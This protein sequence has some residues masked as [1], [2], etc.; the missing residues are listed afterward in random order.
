MVYCELALLAGCKF[1]S[2]GETW[3][4]VST[5]DNASSGFPPLSY[6]TCAFKGKVGTDRGFLRPEAR[7]EGVNATT[8][9]ALAIRLEGV[10][11]EPAGAV[12]LGLNVSGG[13]SSR[14]FLEAA[15]KS[16]FSD[17]TVE[18]RFGLLE[19]G[20]FEKLAGPVEELKIEANL[21]GAD[22]AA[23]PFLTLEHPVYQRYLAETV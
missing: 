20:S 6:K 9:G 17:A 10:T 16:V 21:A 13:E 1:V 7:Y 3:I 15:K 19:L 18:A 14:P 23:V 11:V 12:V 5:S 8:E 4:E 22:S 2:E